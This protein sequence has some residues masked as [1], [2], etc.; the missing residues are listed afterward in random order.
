MDDDAEFPQVF[1]DSIA[2]FTNGTPRFI[3]EFVREVELQGVVKVVNGQLYNTESYTQEFTNIDMG[4]WFHTVMIGGVVT[5]IESL[6]T[7]EQLILKVSYYLCNN[8]MF[9][10]II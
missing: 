9:S 5:E 2:L 3:Y 8:Y 4:K 6:N 10:I 1:H 7:V